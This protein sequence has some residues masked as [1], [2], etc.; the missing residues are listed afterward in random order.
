MKIAMMVATMMN[1]KSSVM[2]VAC[3]ACSRVLRVCVLG[4]SIGDLGGN[5]VPSVCVV[6]VCVRLCA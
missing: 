5:R 2:C 1:K 6:C 4:L 3:G